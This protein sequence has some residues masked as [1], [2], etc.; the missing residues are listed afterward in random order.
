MRFL[1]Q[2]HSV[3]LAV[4]RYDFFSKLALFLNFAV[5]ERINRDKLEIRYLRLK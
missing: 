2:I 3:D 1:Y 5:V 4:Q